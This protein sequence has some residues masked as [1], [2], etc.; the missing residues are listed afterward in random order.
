MS[1]AVCAIGF[2][3][4]RKKGV[5]HENKNSKTESHRTAPA[6]HTRRHPEH[7]ARTCVSPVS[8]KAAETSAN[9]VED[10]VLAEKD[11]VNSTE[12]EEAGMEI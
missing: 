8:R 10:W 4:Y 12:A 3:F 6:G 5:A 9:P 2:M 7:Y 1:F 11:L